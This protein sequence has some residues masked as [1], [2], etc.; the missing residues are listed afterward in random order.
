MWLL[1][2]V[3]SALFAGLTAILAKQGIRNTDSN[4]ATALR[5]C[6]VL[7][8]A[9]LMVFI[10]GAQGELAHI[11]PRTLLFLGL[12]GLATGGSW[13]CYFRALQ[14]GDVNKV[15]PID[16]SST[17]LTMLLAFLLLGERLTWLKALSMAVM[18]LGT[19][20]MIQ[21]RPDE[22][23]AP[24]GPWLLYALG[25]A[26]F[27]SLQAILGRWAYRKS[28]QTLARRCARAWCF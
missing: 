25:A 13:L 23:K 20:M 6:V 3:L 15:T 24:R 8:F 28:T 12:S 2:A 1:F 10:T 27:A 17:I 18:L 7:A 26:A 22:K 9:W 16:K 21:R 11:S 4:L 19:L 5:T 14:L